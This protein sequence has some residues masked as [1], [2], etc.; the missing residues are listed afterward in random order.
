[1]YIHT[2]IHT[3]ISWLKT[4]YVLSYIYHHTSCNITRS[5]C[6]N[7]NVCYKN[8]TKKYNTDII[9]S[10]FVHAISFIRCPL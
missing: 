6:E 2:Y 10:P 8:K 9:F 5:V 7:W 4:I 3:F 1:M